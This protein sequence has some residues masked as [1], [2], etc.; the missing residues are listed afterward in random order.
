MSESKRRF[1]SGDSLQQALVQAANHYHLQ[2]EEIAYQPVEKR[3]GFTK[4]RRK[5]VIE[6]DPAAPRREAA[7]PPP[8]AAPRIG[9]QPAAPMVPAAAGGGERTAAPPLERQPERQP[10][11]TATSHRPSSERSP[12]GFG[13]ASSAG[14]R[15]GGGGEHRGGG[16]EHRGGGGEHR[17][18]PR[19]PSGA[20]PRERRQVAPGALGAHGSGAT[21]EDLVALP[22]R[23]RNAGER[24]PVAEGSQAEAAGKGIQLLLQ[25]AGLNLTPR[26]YQG[27]ERLE[28]DLQGTDT[29]WCFADDGELLMAIE[30]LLPRIIRSISGEAVLCRVDCD[31][32]HEIREERLRSL[33]QKVADEVRQRGRPRTLVPMNPADRRIV[34]VTLAD[35]P[36]VV[37]ESEGEGYF[38]RITV[39][40][41]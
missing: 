18:G 14:P 40:P 39:R 41:A 7:A 29:D 27:E 1:F 13:G 12:S 22:E 3:H 5:F 17:G 38:K 11:R 30:H 24:Y 23:P 8:A 4:V 6:V 15:R 2:P 28:I 37:T 34:H 31:N 25:I 32:F 19:R 20:Y 35:D 33:A 10:S 36:A 16:G 9:T 21:A 26:I